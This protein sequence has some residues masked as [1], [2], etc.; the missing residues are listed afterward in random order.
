MQQLGGL[1]INNANANM[2]RAPG[3]AMN[4]MAVIQL[5]QNLQGLSALAQLTSNL[6]ALT[7]GGGA[8]GMGSG[9]GGG[10]G[11][12][13]TGMSDS[14]GSNPLAALGG[15]GM[16][17]GALGL[18]GGGGA[19]LPGSM[20]GLPF[21]DSGS[22]SRQVFVRNVSKRSGIFRGRRLLRG[23]GKYRGICC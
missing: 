21:G 8:G 2:S 19:P 22:S 5:L 10:V 7:G 11:G 17:S 15:L 1:G 23:L 20:A 14:S 9:L 16:L 12:G 3:A 18:G 13:P 4:P 6:G